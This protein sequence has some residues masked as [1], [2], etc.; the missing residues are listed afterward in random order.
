MTLTHR[1][2]DSFGNPLLTAQ[3]PGFDTFFPKLVIEDGLGNVVL[4]QKDSS[5]WNGASFDPPD[6][7]SYTATL[8]LDTGPHQ[9]V[10]Q[11]S[12]SFTVG[13]PAAT[14]KGLPATIIGTGGPDVI[15]GTA[16]DDVIAGLGGDDAIDG[17]GGNDIICAGP[18]HDSVS[19]GPGNDRVYGEGGRDKLL[20][21]GGRDRLFGG[22]G[23]DVLKGRGGNDKLL[24]NKGADKL[25]GGAGDN[26]MACGPGTDTANG[27]PGT[28]TAVGC[29]AV[30]GVPLPLGRRVDE[31]LCNQRC[32]VA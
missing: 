26:E 4:D 5:L 25:V 6:D 13:L 19:G 10:I 14:C 16:G 18:G 21:G 23:P 15:N 29:E 1:F 9:G 22:P 8:S 24:G 30:T 11:N 7:G 20:G 3:M 27:G 31:L 12:T 28:D 17:L 32:L 2:E